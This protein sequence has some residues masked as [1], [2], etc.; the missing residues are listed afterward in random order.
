MSTPIR[1]MWFVPQPLV[2]FA[3]HTP[4]G[5][6]VHPVDT[7][8]SDE[9]YNKLVT[10]EADVVVT[11]MDNV[12]GWNLRPGPKDFRVIAQ[13]E[14]T[15]PLSL[16]ANPEFGCLLDLRGANLLVDAL[17]NGFVVAL[18]AMLKDAGLEQNDYVLKPAGGV[19][20]RYKSMLAGSGDATLLG[21]QLTSKAVEAGFVQVASVQ[22]A[23]PSFPGQG[24]VMRMSNTQRDRIG[25]WLREL[26]EA[27]KSTQLLDSLQPTDEGIAIL[28]EHRRMLGLPGGEDNYT[29]IVDASL[30]Y[31]YLG[32]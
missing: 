31:Q 18:R 26:D 11:A 4:T 8:S 24:I 30:I 14:R 20:E 15:T 17:D 25:V 12:I 23:Y 9:Q 6:L 27:R 19:I 32:Q 16:I 2:V 21:D 28:T 10:G 29:Q 13:V 1:L 22:Q 5:T 3:G 7:Q